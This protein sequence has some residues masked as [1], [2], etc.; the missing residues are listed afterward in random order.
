[1][2]AHG[3]RIITTG[4]V[5]LLGLA[6][7]AGAED[8][9]VLRPAAGGVAPGKQLEHWLKHEFYQRVDRRSAAFEKMLKSESALRA[10]Q[11]E[12]KAFFLRQLGGLPERTPLNARVVGRL[13]GRGYR[14]E[15]VRFESRPVAR[16]HRA[17][18]PQSRRQGGRRLSAGL[19]AARP[20]RDGG[21]VL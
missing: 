20:P 6:C 18:R 7:P 19:R 11:A 14:V 8:L 9:S 1:M 21:D 3:V 16:R 4:F 12:R 13:Q 2:K 17:V 15:N 10:W 5:F